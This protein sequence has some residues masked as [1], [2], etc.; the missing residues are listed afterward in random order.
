MRLSSCRL[1]VVSWRLSGLL[2][3]PTCN[4][5]PATQP[6]TEAL[7]ANREGAEVQRAP[8]VF[9]EH[10]QQLRLVKTHRH[11]SA[12]SRLTFSMSWKLFRPSTLDRFSSV[13]GF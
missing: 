11:I 13:R 2:F 8:D 10:I 3:R 4:L 9:T 7:K 6:V 1:Q 5:Q 12:F